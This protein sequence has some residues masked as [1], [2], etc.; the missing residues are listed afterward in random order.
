M[1]DSSHGMPDG[2]W[3]V[4]TERHPVTVA[5]YPMIAVAATETPTATT[6]LMLCISIG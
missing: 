1:S 6:L 4:V 3:T 2:L 5:A